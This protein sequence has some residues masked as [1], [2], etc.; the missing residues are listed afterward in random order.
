[1][2]IIIQFHMEVCDY[3]QKEQPTTFQARD[4]QTLDGHPLTFLL[5]G[6][7]HVGDLIDYTSYQSSISLVSFCCS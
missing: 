4:R 2:T 1:M 6:I 7:M 3:L 5:N